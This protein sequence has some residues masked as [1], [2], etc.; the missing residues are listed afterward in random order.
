M[1]HLIKFLKNNYLITLA[2]SPLIFLIL[3]FHNPYYSDDYQTIIGLKL[4][5]L[6]QQQSYFSL[7]DVFTLRSDGHLVPI[8]YYVNQFLPEN[9]YVLHFLIVFS[10]YLSIL[11]FYKILLLLKLPNNQAIMSCI[12]Y[13]FFYIF[14]IKP[15]VWNVFHSHIT[16]SLTGLL[17]IFFIMNFISSK[18][19]LFL[20]FY[21]F[22][23][24]L[25]VFNSESGLIYPVISFFLILLFYKSKNIFI[26]LL[27]LLPNFLYFY[28]SYIFSSKSNFPTIF[29]SRIL[30]NIGDFFVFPDFDKSL[31]SLILEY[32]SRKSP[33]NFF[34]YIIIFLDNIL[35]FLNLTTYEYIFRYFKSSLLKILTLIAFIINFILISIYLTKFF[36]RREIIKNKIFLK[37]FFLFLICLF[38]YSF[39]FHRKD[40]CIGLA[41]FSSVIYSFVFEYIKSHYSIKKSFFF[42]GVLLFPSFMYALTGF[43]EVYEMR[44]RTFI[45]EMHEVHYQN[46]NSTSINKKMIYY[47]DFI[48]LYCLRNFSKYK[49]NLMTFKNL[50]LYEFEIEF[51]KNVDI[52]ENICSYTKKK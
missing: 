1:N 28:L 7:F 30:K 8:L 16:N 14:T 52:S 29:E 13:S 22:F 49:E 21:I 51:F 12:I 34:G 39:L 44:S 40:I 26:Y 48:S 31:K 6:I 24:I 36:I 46:L 35:N 20:I 19:I 17:S 3:T 27:I 38:I 23:S 42:I 9:E 41:L 33:N 32:R 18:K 11:I 15:L 37:Y 4:Y 45:K 10:F 5:N 50:S 2:I 47:S 43:E 25:T